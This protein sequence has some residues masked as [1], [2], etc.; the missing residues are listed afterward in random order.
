M[1]TWVMEALYAA[2]TFSKFGIRTQRTPI[3]QLRF[4]WQRLADEVSNEA[5]NYDVF[6]EF[7]NL[8]IQ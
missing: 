5:A 1:G 6:A 3:Q 8:R 2:P 4:A 7:G